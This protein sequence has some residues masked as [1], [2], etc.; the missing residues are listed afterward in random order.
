MI[1]F[2]DFSKDELHHIWRRMCKEAKWACADD[3]SLVASRRVARGI[4]RKG[5]GN[6]RTVRKLFE[7]A[8][9]S[10]KLRFLAAGPGARPTI[11]MVDII[12][13][14]PT[15]ESNAALDAA[16]TVGDCT[17]HFFFFFPLPQR[18]ARD[19]G[20]RVVNCASHV[21]ELEG[22]TGLGTVKSELDT[23]LAVA[24]GNYYHELKGERIDDL[25][26]NRL[27]VGEAV[28][29]WHLKL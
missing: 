26:L 10:A 7:S 12:G 18:C 20:P 27:F 9:S 11:Q 17:V 25:A 28:G 29:Q 16:L 21:Q 8:V 14:E 15:R 1:P 5:F 4:G 22:M 19:P 24:F 6:A 23:I 2:D 13:S 3:V